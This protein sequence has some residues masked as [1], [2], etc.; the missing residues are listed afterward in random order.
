MGV[1]MG[2]IQIK[3]GHPLALNGAALAPFRANGAH[4]SPVVFSFRVTV[5]LLD[6][7]LVVQRIRACA[8]KIP[9]EVFFIFFY[10]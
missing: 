1:K 10:E 6:F 5:L 4:P 9:A 8:I 7:R 2:W 3:M